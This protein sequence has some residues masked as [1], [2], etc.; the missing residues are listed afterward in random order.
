[1][2][3]SGVS[4]ELV[5]VEYDVKRAMDGIRASELPD[6]FAEILRTGGTVPAQAAGE[7]SHVAGTES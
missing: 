3:G 7:T 5:R 6:D 4:V 1:M 2:D